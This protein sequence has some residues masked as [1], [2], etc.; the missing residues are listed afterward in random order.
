MGDVSF[1]SDERALWR[2]WRLPIA[3]EAVLCAGLATIAGSL[4]AWLA[5][6]GGDLA[7]HEYQRWLYLVHGFTLWDNFWYAGRYA[8]VD[9][10]VLYYPL[11]AFIGIRVLAVLTVAVAA[12][13]FA[14]VAEREWGSA[15]RW[16]GRA[17][18]L[19]WAGVIL[20]GEFPFAL[21]AT[22]ALVALL[23]L[24]RGRRWIAA[25]VIVLVLAASPVAFVL[26][27]VVL[28]GIVA[29]R[30]RVL[31]GRTVPALAFVLAAA[32]ELLVVHLFPS[33]T[34]QFP[35]VEALEATAFCVG[36]LALAWRLERARGLRGVLVVYLLTVVAVY[37]IPSG[38]GHN[39][40]RLRELA[41]PLALL[42][43]A[44][45]R[46]RPLPLALGA[47]VLAG[48]WNILPLADNWAQAAADQSENPA[49]WKA[50][51][52]Y[53]RTHLSTGYRV[54]AVDTSQHW[55]AFYLARA[56]VPLV[57]GWFRQDDRP[58]AGLLY[59]HRYTPAQYVAWL[60]R[61][62]VQYVVLT[63]SPPDY[64]S[65][66]EA[67]IVRSGDAGLRRVFASRAV[68]I[69]TVPRPRPIV[70]G[71][72]QPAVLAFRESRLRIRVSRGGTYGVAVR[73]SPYWHSSTGCLFRARGG[74][75]SLRTDAAATVRIGFDIDAS[76]LFSAFADTTPRCR[77]G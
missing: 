21:G 60:H 64:S 40:G 6:P 47:V 5:P 72:G 73:W 8:F 23:A 70:T 65:R 45:R 36:L 38:L 61:L 30:P 67:R 11:A 3:R 59:R 48:A 51:V 74:M 69:Y 28:V 14:L 34:L 56:D 63:D 9:Y 46:W 12:A 53:L 33:G 76:S 13:A 71:P 44:L 26:L 29:A 55:P 50:P 4:L 20:T 75:L 77:V 18:A 62:G 54:E 2:M 32:A 58:V 57:R 24:Q 68:S 1:A 25:V 41:L 35:G 66:R 19:V 15:A 27:A 42:V 16:S 39:I 31:R 37:A 7:A 22:L 49:V 43:V 52:G 10:S 17:F